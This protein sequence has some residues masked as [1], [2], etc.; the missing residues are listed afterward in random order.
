MIKSLFDKEILIADLDSLNELT[1]AEV[2]LYITDSG[3]E[4]KVDFSKFQNLKHLRCDNGSKYRQNINCLYKLRQLVLFKYDINRE[5]IS[6]LVNLEYLS[7]I[8]GNYTDLNF[9][10]SFEGLKELELN[11][12]KKLT[13]ISVLKGNRSISRLE[14]EGCKKIENI[15]DVIS[16][17]TNL[18]SL[19]LFGVKLESVNWIKKLNKLNQLWIYESNI[20]D[21]DISPIAHIKNVKID[22]RK[23]YNYKYDNLNLQ[24]VPK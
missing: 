4:F 12:A 7:L 5:S 24:I 14:F 15:E 18:E 10:K 19:I 17:M 20:I 16:S 23:H 11:F 9:L 13:D 21:G 8:H 22:N 2:S 1:G 6:D 3:T